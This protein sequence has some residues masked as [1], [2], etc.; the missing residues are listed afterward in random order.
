MFERCKRQDFPTKFFDV[1]S[2]LLQVCPS[3][4]T[5]NMPNAFT[6]PR[7]QHT[8]K[9]TTFWMDIFRLLQIGFMSTFFIRVQTESMSVSWLKY[10]PGQGLPFNSNLNRNYIHLLI[11]VKTQLMI[12]FCLNYKPKHISTFW[13][14]CKTWPMCPFWGVQSTNWSF[15]RVVA[16]MWLWKTSWLFK[17][18]L[19][20]WN[21]RLFF[22]CNFCF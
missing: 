12:C 22:F 19:V 5:Q 3:S 16:K 8:P 7:H 17:E 10:K 13:L 2:P 18:G 14:R 1:K 15:W 11:Q 4:R 6:Y 20:D 9:V 21:T